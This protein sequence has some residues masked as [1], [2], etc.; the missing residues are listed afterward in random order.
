M[1]A[2]RMLAVLA[3]GLGLV[4]LLLMILNAPPQTTRAWPAPTA[5]SARPTGPAFVKAGGNGDW[6]LQDD[7]CGSIQYALEQG[8]PGRGDTIYVAEGAYT[9]T[10]GAV[11]TVTESVTLYGGWD[12]AAS[13]PV[14][15]D[16]ENYVTT[17][18]GQ[19]QRRVVHLDGRLK[20]ITPTVDGFVIA[21]G[22]AAHAHLN[23]GRG[24]GIH[25]LGAT[26][27][28]ANNVISNNIAGPS[29]TDG[30]AYGGGIYL[31]NPD[32]TA[33][34]TANRIISNVANANGHGRGGGVYLS[35]APK[36]QVMNNVVLSNTAVLTGNSGYGGGIALASSPDVVVAGNQIA[37]NVA[38]RG[39]DW[40]S[41]D[42]GGLYCSSSHDLT[43]RENVVQHNVVNLN[44]GG[45]TGGGIQLWSCYRAALAHN[46]FEGNASSGQ[47]SGSGGGLYTYAARDLTLEANRFVDN[48]AYQGG[49]LYLGHNT[50]FTMT[51]NVVA[52]NVGGHAGGGMA[53]E[54]WS[55]EPVTGALAHNT[56]AANDKGNWDGRIAIHL[57][58][59]YVTLFLTNNLIYSHTYGV[60]AVTTSTVQLDHTLFYANKSG[61]TGGPGVI[62][63]TNPIT[64]QDPLLTG[65]YHLSYGSP[66]IDAGVDAGVTDD[67]DGDLR[68]AEGGY[69]IGADE[70]YGGQIYLPLVI[71]AATSRTV[72]Y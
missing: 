13:G 45:G 12:G 72:N 17:L 52:E 62:V 34:I 41:S 39:A 68:P 71:R 54:A 46:L 44:A 38:Y 33:V 9:G 5:G 51:N 57:N 22:N 55:T 8:E 14:V 65:D 1:H 61:N 42:G 30:R 31:L 20:P 2:R 56:F 6:C 66:A 18:D 49:G 25:S 70:F 19:G 64:G 4:L 24:G 26:A 15:R 50:W 58:D 63:N 16:P 23:S 43:F 60:Y 11:I 36:A 47:N 53:F 3:L 40:E 35:D 32:G 27:L 59:S 67:I 69:D 29:D 48:S 37:Y 10:G 7:P 21:N 28:I